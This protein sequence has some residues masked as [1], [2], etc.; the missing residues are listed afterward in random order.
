[1][2]VLRQGLNTF[3]SVLSRSLP[4]SLSTRIKA[5]WSGVSSGWGSD[6]FKERR[7][8]VRAGTEVDGWINRWMDAPLVR[9]LGRER[10]ERAFLCQHQKYKNK[11]MKRRIKNIRVML[12]SESE[13]QRP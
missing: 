11:Y 1:M 7:G 3:L 13:Q 6:D 5:D 4:R 8:D 2:S 10:G 12:Q 9:R